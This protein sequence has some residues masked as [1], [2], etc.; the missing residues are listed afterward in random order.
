VR[1]YAVKT[2][3]YDIP[4]AEAC[5]RLGFSYLQEYNLNQA[6]F[7]YEMATKLEK[8]QGSLGFFNDECWTWLPHLQLCVCYDKLGKHKLAYEHNEIARQFRPNDARIL[9]NINY[10]NSLKL[11]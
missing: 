3:E 2:F 5:C 4:R 7:W 8:P 10:F 1:K 9:Y 11:E 6:V